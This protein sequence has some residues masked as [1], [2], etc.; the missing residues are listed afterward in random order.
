MSGRETRPRIGWSRGLA[1]VLGGLP[2]AVGVGLL[3]GLGGRPLGIVLGAILMLPLWVAAMV[4][5]WLAPKPWQAWAGAGA[6]T[7]LVGLLW[8]L[9]R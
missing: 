9:L 3:L 8:G 4:A 7:A 6:A 5:A 1:G 2:P